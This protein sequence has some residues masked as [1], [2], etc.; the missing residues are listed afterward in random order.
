LAATTKRKHAAI[1]KKLGG[2]N[3]SQ[4]VK[5]SHA[6]AHAATHRLRVGARLSR[7]HVR[8]KA[9]RLRRVPAAAAAKP[10]G[11]GG[12]QADQ[13]VDGGEGGR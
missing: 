11:E 1:M 4:K 12:Q 10:R 2:K 13:W 8:A 5:K 6:A 7:P 3:P 9:R